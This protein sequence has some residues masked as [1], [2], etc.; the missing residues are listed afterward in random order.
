M[1]CHQ[2]DANNNGAIDRNELRAA[3]GNWKELLQSKAAEGQKS[4]A[5]AC[6]IQ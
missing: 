1:G 3:L 4:A 6:A 5:C 2:A